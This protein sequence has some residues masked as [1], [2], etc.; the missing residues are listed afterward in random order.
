MIFFVLDISSAVAVNIPPLVK[1][2]YCYLVCFN[3][4]RRGYAYSGLYYISNPKVVSSDGYD[5][6]TLH[7]DGNCIWFD[8][9]DKDKDY[10]IATQLDGGGTDLEVTYDLLFVSILYDHLKI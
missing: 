6:V 7:S 4:W 1:D 2:N 5:D 10:M 3:I 8:D 9:L